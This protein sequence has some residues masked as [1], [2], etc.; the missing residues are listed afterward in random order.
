[1]QSVDAVRWEQRVRGRVQHANDTRCAARIRHA[2]C[3]TH[4]TRIRHALCSTQRHALCS[5]QKTRAMQR[6]KDTRYAARKR[7]ALCSTQKKRAVQRTRGRTEE[8]RVKRRA[9]LWGLC[10]SARSRMAISFTARVAWLT[11]TPATGAHDLA[12]AISTH[13]S[14]TAQFHGGGGGMHVASESVIA[15]MT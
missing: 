15:W 2:L 6:A 14:W 5:T 7:R 3:S 10:S 1:M 4:Q 9:S 11:L 13:N 8:A 12:F